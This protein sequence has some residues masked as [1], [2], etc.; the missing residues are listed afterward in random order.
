MAFGRRGA[1]D[2]DTGYRH[3]GYRDTGAVVGLLSSRRRRGQIP[4]R[5]CGHCGAEA[6]IDMIDMARARAYLTCRSCGNEWDTDRLQVLRP[7]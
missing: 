6:R 7:A 5:V 3:R 2:S 4:G 1:Q